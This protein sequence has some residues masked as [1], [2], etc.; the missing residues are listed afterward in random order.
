MSTLSHFKKKKNTSLTL[1]SPKTMPET[2]NYRSSQVSRMEPLSA[3]LKSPIQFSEIKEETQNGFKL[4]QID[5]STL[6][7]ALKHSEM[8]P[9]LYQEKLE[10]RQELIQDS[11]YKRADTNIVFNFTSGTS[12]NQHIE[13]R[14]PL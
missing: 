1:C 14:I 8:E 2:E 9:K 7:V 10:K 12:F 4:P 5:F 6:D 11:A 13:K 3:L